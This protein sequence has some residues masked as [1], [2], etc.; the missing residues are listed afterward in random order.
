M[1][2]FSCDTRA[3]RLASSWTVLAALVL[4]SSLLGCDGAKKEASASGQNGSGQENPGTNSPD[5]NSPDSNSP[6]GSTGG[7]QGK[8]PD[9]NDPFGGKD[10]KEIIKSTPKPDPKRTVILGSGKGKWKQTSF[11]AKPLFAQFD[12]KIKGLKRAMVESSLEID[13]P[14]FG[15]GIT[16]DYILVQDPKRMAVAF[17]ILDQTDPTAPLPKTTVAVDG[18]NVQTVDKFGAIK[19]KPKV[20]EVDITRFGER[21]SQYVASGVLHGT[22]VFAK[23][24]AQAQKEGWK[25]E[26]NSF[27]EG[28]QKLKR[29]LLTSP[30]KQKIEIISDDQ[31]GLPTVVR[32]NTPSKDGEKRTLWTATYRFKGSDLT[33]ADFKALPSEARIN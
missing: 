11:E 9:P 10:P 32:V 6:S 22:P 26:T 30:T 13:Y 3:L 25:V 27:A 7:D 24:L 17:T 5:S 21:L 33:E 16:K 15:R 14:K 23:A 29:V 12:S 18:A 1:L 19:S 31:F 2:H 8:K 20:A 4:G 28:T